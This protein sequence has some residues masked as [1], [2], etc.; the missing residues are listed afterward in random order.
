MKIPSFVLSKSITR[1]LEI[2]VEYINIKSLKMYP[3]LSEL[4]SKIIE[5]LL[6]IFALIN[7]KRI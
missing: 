1:Q 7:D 4:T 3:L 5:N 6:N 2:Y